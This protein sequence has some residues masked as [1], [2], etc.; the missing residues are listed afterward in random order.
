MTMTRRDLFAE[1]AVD[2]PI[3]DAQTRVLARAAL[4]EPQPPICLVVFCHQSRTTRL[5]SFRQ[6]L[7]LIRPINWRRF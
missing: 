5:L 4:I 1:I 6:R 2:H 3:A 7:S